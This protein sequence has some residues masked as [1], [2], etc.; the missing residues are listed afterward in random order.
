MI[1]ISVTELEKKYNDAVQADQASYDE[2]RTN[3]LLVS[4]YHYSKRNSKFFDKI[5]ETKSLAEDTKLRITKNHIGKIMRVYS[6]N[7]LTYAPGA[8]IMARDEANTHDKVYAEISRSVWEDGKY[9]ANYSKLRRISVDDYFDLGETWIKLTFEP[10]L[11]EII[12]YA[13]ASDENGQPIL[14]EM[15][16]QTPDKESPVM[17]GD[18]KQEILKSYDI[19][20]DKDALSI[21]DSQFIGIKKLVSTDELKQ[22]IKNDKTLTEERKEEILTAIGSASKDT[23]S[24]FVGLDQATTTQENK[25]LLKEFWYRPSVIYPMGYFYI[26]ISGAIIWEG[27]LQKDKFGKPIF[28]IIYCLCDEFPSARR[29]VSPI[30]QG[31][32]CQAEIN[33]A[34]SKIAETQITLGDDKI[35]TTGGAGITEGAKLNGMR[36]VILE[37]GGEYTIVQGR[38]GEQY[39]PYLQNQITELYNIMGVA[40]DGIEKNANQD[41]LAT[42]YESLKNKKRFVFYSEKYERFLVE[43]C[44][45]YLKLAQ[46]Y[47]REDRV[48]NSIGTCEAINV[49]EFKQ[50]DER[51]YDIKVIPQTDDIETTMGRYMVLTNSLQYGSL[52]PET[53]GRVM[54]AMPFIDKGIYKHL[55]TD[56]DESRNICLALDRGEDPAISKYDNNE[57]IVA[58][59]MR[60]MRESDYKY[61]IQKKP[62][63]QE[64]YEN[65]YAERDAIVQQQIAELKAANS[66][67]IPTGGPKIKVDAYVPDPKDPTKTQRAAISQEAFN[68]LLDRIEKQMPIQT[69]IAGTPTQTQI[70]SLGTPNQANPRDIAPQGQGVM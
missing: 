38:S 32:P 59:L 17:E 7:L 16:Q 45:V 61:L 1:K 53:L 14:D 29:G 24:M 68:W 70:D 34:A 62:E 18:I 11:G 55:T 69:A 41:M 36:Q 47:Y 40:E 35:V 15:G 44:Q 30:R 20:I 64:L 46:S 28:P 12:G 5:R 19:F 26:M 13:P 39:L 43:W 49:A 33:R 65:Q 27:E 25:T 8:T 22:Q 48:I 21:D 58:A 42:L 57:K 60:R 6:N 56:F 9:R 4:G 50:I 31:R 10:D 3:I 66:D 37:A 52:D 2:M 51:A 67:I 63:I 23:Y 54:E